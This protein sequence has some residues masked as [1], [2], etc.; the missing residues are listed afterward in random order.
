MSTEVNDAR[1]QAIYKL[2]GIKEMMARLEHA[3][4]CK[5]GDDCEFAS[6]N[7][8]W[9]NEPWDEMYISRDE[10]HDHDAAL[11][12]ITE[13]PLSVETRQGW[14]VAGG[15]SGSSPVEYQILLCTGGPAVR[16]VGDLGAYSEPET[17]R[18]EYQDWGTPWTSLEMFSAP[19]HAKDF[20]ADS[21]TLLAYARQFW[22]GE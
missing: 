3:D 18:L 9:A 11:E 17:A 16:L 6:D 4:S 20:E 12:A 14:I 7:N 22:F 15:P 1:Q 10:Y 19:L 5:N 21:A 2:E 8:D 13:S